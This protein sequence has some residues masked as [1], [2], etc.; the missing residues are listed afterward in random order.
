VG[1]LCHD[2]FAGRNPAW[3]IAFDIPSLQSAEDC[4]GAEVLDRVRHMDFTPCRDADYF[5]SDTGTPPEDAAHPDRLR[6]ILEGRWRG[7]Q[8]AARPVSADKPKP[9]EEFGAPLIE[10]YHMSM[11]RQKMA[12]TEG[13]MPCRA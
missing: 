3:D 11:A 1:T 6:A 10:L 2:V 9:G 8:G 4:L 7:S 12:A 13:E 5:A